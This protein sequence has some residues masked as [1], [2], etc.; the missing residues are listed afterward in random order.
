MPFH[1]LL[2]HFSLTSRYVLSATL[3][4]FFSFLFLFLSPFPHCLLSSILHLFF[5]F[6]FACVT[7]CFLVFWSWRAVLSLYSFLSCL[8]CDDR[9]LF[10]S[11]SRYV[12][13]T[14]S[15]VFFFSSLLSY[16]SSL[17]DSLLS[18]FY[19]FICLFVF[20]FS[21]LSRSSFLLDSMLS[22]SYSFIC[23][24]LFFS[25][26]IVFFSSRHHVIFFL[27]LPLFSSFLHYHH[28]LLFFSTPC[29]LLSILLFVFSFSSVS[30]SPFLLDSMLSS[31]YCFI[32]F[33]LFFG[34]IIAIL[35]SRLHTVFSQLFYLFS[36][37]LPYHHRLLFFSTPCCL[38]STIICFLLYFTHR[39]FF[40]LLN[41]M[42]HSLPSFISLLFLLSGCY[43]LLFSTPHYFYSFLSLLV[44][45][46]VTNF[47]LSSPAGGALRGWAGVPHPREWWW[48]AFRARSGLPPPLLPR[49][50]TCEYLPLFF[51]LIYY[52]CGFT[53][54]TTCEGF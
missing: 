26:I 49:Q 19:C 13:P 50:D 15:F 43:C 37:F 7:I 47:L 14:P 8:P 46:R 10:F 24:L 52:L 39:R 41:T 32:C 27:L 12:L 18:S 16:P 23:F 45:L 42:T 22:S 2:S 21:S 35:S 9:L 51:F 17:L 25:I 4:S 30:S 44:F 20:S 28:R 53:C 6:S 11:S 5:F 34:F 1:F 3:F 54:M 48:R 33:L 40:F 29:C 31:F 36:S 38:L